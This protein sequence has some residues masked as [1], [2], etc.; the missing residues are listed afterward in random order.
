VPPSL[1]HHQQIYPFLFL[2]SFE[3]LGLV[4]LVFLSLRGRLETVAFSHAR[5]TMLHVEIQA[6]SVLAH[7]FF[8]LAHRCALAGNVHRFVANVLA[9]V[10]H[11]D[12]VP[13]CA[14]AR[15][16][17]DPYLTAALRFLA[18]RAFIAKLLTRH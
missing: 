2:A 14:P 5:T 6:I 9:F 8:L 3:K 16:R 12:V 7:F 13:R 15:V 18:R 4:R 1:D 11:F 17:R 10:A